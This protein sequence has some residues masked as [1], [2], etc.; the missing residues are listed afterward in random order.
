MSNAKSSSAETCSAGKV[1][2][3]WCFVA[4]TKVLTENG[5]VSIEKIKKGDKVYT[6]NF[7]TESYEFKEVL[8]T[9]T[10]FTDEVITISTNANKIET[11]LSHQFW[12][13]DKGKWIRAESL[14]PGMKLFSKN[15]MVRPSKF[16]ETN[17]SKR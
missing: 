9:V 15:K 8:H 13:V 1:R 17:F 14:L 5:L 12:V 2:G 3:S 10:S 4:G 6:Y 11:T 16:D 7:K